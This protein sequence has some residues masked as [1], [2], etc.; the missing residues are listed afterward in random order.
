MDWIMHFTIPKAVCEKRV[1][2]ELMF[3]DQQMMFC[4]SRVN[5]FMKLKIPLRFRYDK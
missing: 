3:Y 5:F 1:I 2:N 4:F